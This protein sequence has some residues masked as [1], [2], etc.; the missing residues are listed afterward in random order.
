MLTAA[1]IP[2]YT[3][4]VLLPYVQ[5]LDPGVIH[6]QLLMWRDDI[7]L[8]EPR[9][10]SARGSTAPAVVVSVDPS[11]PSSQPPW[12]HFGFAIPTHDLPLLV[13]VFHAS[14]DTYSTQLDD[15]L[16]WSP[17]WPERHAAVAGCTSSIVVSMI[18]HRAVNHAT[19]LLA[20][21]SI[22]DTVLGS[23]DDLRTAVLHWL[24]SQRVLPFAQYRMLRMELGPCGPAINVRI[25]PISLTDVVADTVG[26]SGL[27]LPDLQAITPCCDPAILTG[28]LVSLARSMFVG[29]PLDVAWTEQSAIVL[30]CRDALTVQLD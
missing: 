16:A 7:T 18:A 21:L 24:P 13:H 6:S 8:I 28:R 15:A 9:K 2:R 19:L 22:L 26:L 25:A 30:P 11:K 4:Q 5:A 29:D 10:R 23:I 20:F 27:G 3:V 1:P 14:P 17:S 12:D